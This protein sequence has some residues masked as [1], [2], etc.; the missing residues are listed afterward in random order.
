MENKNIK[1]KIYEKKC[2]V[3]GKTT[4]VDIYEQGKC[5]YCG[6][7]NCFLNEENP[8][9]VALP[10]TLSLNRARQLFKE[11]KPFDL[12]LNDFIEALYSY[13]EMQFEYNGTYYAVE[14]VGKNKD[15]INIQLYNSKTKEMSIY[16]D[17]TDF[18]NN[19]K[20]EGK[21]LRDVWDETTDRYWLQ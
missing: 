14:L 1:D 8:N 16:K 5:K 6:W 18:K 19:A 15:E 12:D 2:E 20:V 10:N 17:E 13:G 21:L 4:K 3:C 9:I 11:G 7:F